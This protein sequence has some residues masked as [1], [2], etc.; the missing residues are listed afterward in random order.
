MGP[1][2]RTHSAML[3]PHLMLPYPLIIG[4]DP[5][6]TT[7]IVAI[8]LDPAP[9]VVLTMHDSG[10]AAVTWLADLLDR[11]TPPGDEHVVAVER[12]NIAART[13]RGTRDGTLEALY[14]IGAVRYICG[15]WGVPMRLQEVSTAKHAFNDD[16][17]RRLDLYDR[18][19]GPHERDALRHALLCARARGWEGTV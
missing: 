10:P 5:G 4:A 19:H 12:F 17:L 8:H 16:V 2:E 3:S 18:V 9:Q 6:G 11:I 15:V 14:T 7:G 13:L 1:E